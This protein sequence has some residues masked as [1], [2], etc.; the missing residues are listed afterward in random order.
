M[1]AEAQKLLIPVVF[2][3]SCPDIV[4]TFLTLVEMHQHGTYT[5]LKAAS[6]LCVAPSVM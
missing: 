4:S 1:S 5:C 3:Q 2:Q 6:Q